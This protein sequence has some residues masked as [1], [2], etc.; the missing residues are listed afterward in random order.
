M[1]NMSSVNNFDAVS[2]ANLNEF[3]L[4]I[5]QELEIFSDLL[6]SIDANCDL[7][8][9]S[10]LLNQARTHISKVQQLMNIELRQK[11]SQAF[12]VSVKARTPK[13]K[14]CP[15]F[16]KYM[17]AETYPYE[18]YLA[19]G[20]RTEPLTPSFDGEYPKLSLINNEGKNA[21]K[22]VHILVAEA[23]INE[24][25]PIPKG[26]DVDHDD[27]NRFNWQV[28]NLQIISK[29]DNQRKRGS[30]VFVEA[31]EVTGLRPLTKYRGQD[32]TEDKL[33]L[34]ATGDNEFKFY[35]LEPNGKYRLCPIT[36]GNQVKGLLSKSRGIKSLLKDNPEP[37]PEEEDDDSFAEL[38]PE[39]EEELEVM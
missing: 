10:S 33:Y 17:M 28:S 15:Q 30:A 13:L 12:K 2:A 3:K 20:S 27:T 18:L 25:Q 11:M 22:P 7:L 21:V 34:K 24:G 32:I 1:P 16:K 37:D 26:F 8:A 36:K 5:Q 9:A 39:E 4:N 23:K 19:S 29:K 38:E 6:G 31:S 35:T 14:R